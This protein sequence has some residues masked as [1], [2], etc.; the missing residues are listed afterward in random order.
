MVHADKVQPH[1]PWFDW[2]ELAMAVGRRLV[3][4][5]KICHPSRAGK[6][7]IGS[8]LSRQPPKPKTMTLPSPIEK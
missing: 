4:Q 6:L 5:P 7:I 1:L 2:T 8:R 3:E